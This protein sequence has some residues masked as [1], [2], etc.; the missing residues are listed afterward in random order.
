MVMSTK[1]HYVIYDPKNKLYL[2]EVSHWG[3]DN[4]GIV[5]RWCFINDPSEA[6]K[7]TRK[8]SD[9]QLSSLDPARFVSEIPLGYEPVKPENLEVRKMTITYKLEA[10]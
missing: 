8:R 2:E 4:Q 3:Y 9:E 1:T 5:W 6:Y 7:T 10:K